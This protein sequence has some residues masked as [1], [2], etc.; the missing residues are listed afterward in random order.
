VG[1]RD[2]RPLKPTSGTAAQRANATVRP[3][4]DLEDTLLRIE[5]SL[6]YFLTKNWSVALGY[7]FERFDQSDFRTDTLNPFVPGSASIWLGNDLRDYTAHIL[8]MS[9]A[10]R[11]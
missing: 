5:A 4:P 10:Y 3:F 2:V 6:R 7:I 11:F 1:H 9:V 8:V